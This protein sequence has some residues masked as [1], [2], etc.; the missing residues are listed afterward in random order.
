M[1]RFRSDFRWRFCIK[2]SSALDIRSCN[3]L[4]RSSSYA[5][6]LRETDPPGI[7]NNYVRMNSKSDDRRWKARNRLPEIRLR[8]YIRL[9][10]LRLSN[11][12][13]RLTATDTLAV[14]HDSISDVMLLLSVA[15]RIASASI[16]RAR[17]RSARY[18][19]SKRSQSEKDRKGNNARRRR[20]WSNDQ[21]HEFL[22]RTSRILLQTQ[23]F[24]EKIEI[25]G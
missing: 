12:R 16:K 4:R 13:N 11:S 21:T 18:S 5:L 6:F 7:N 1:L 25:L 15:S 2:F 20:R 14:R 3:F 19:G 8:D 9:I 10:T 24:L 23:T 22:P 17:D